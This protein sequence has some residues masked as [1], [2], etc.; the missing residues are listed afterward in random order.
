MNQNRDKFSIWQIFVWA[1]V[2]LSRMATSILKSY[3]LL[4]LSFLIWFISYYFFN[5]AFID[6]GGVFK[7]CFLRHL[8]ACTSPVELNDAFDSVGYVEQLMALSNFHVAAHASWQW[9]LTCGLVY[10]SVDPFYSLEFTQLFNM[11]AQLY[12]VLFHLVRFLSF[13][14]WFYLWKKVLGPITP[15]FFLCE[16]D[17]GFLYGPWSLTYPSY[18]RSGVVSLLKITLYS[19]IKSQASSITGYS[20]LDNTFLWIEPMLKFTSDE[21]TA[22]IEFLFYLLVTVSQLNDCFSVL[23]V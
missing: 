20:F 18:I 15:L 12:E 5:I 23:Y 3:I 6:D 2:T 14:S 11:L 4:I 1:A 22:G 13:D 19:F 7:F 10:W 21:L 16:S 9:K 8:T 17:T